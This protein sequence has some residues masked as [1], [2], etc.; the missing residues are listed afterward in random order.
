MNFL[1]HIYLSG[2]N[3]EIKI[4]NFIAD[5]IKGK[6]YKEYPLE[7]QKGVLLHRQIDSFTDTHPIVRISK[8]RLHS[9]YRH[10]DGVIIDILYDH[11]LAKNWTSYSKIPLQEYVQHFYSLLTANYDTLPEKIQHMLPFMI[12]G[13][14]LYNYRTMEGIEKVLQGMNRR[15]KNRSQMHLAIEDLALYYDKFENDFTQFFEKLCI[16]C[17]EKLKTLTNA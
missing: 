15:T 5:A 17:N 4:G 11:Y 12:D 10:Y 9:R 13:N 2:N 6:K 16:F 3:D 7:I 14:W 1:A 8:K